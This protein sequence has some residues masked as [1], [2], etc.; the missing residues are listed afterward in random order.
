MGF[1]M[2]PQT[3]EH[4]DHMKIRGSG[5]EV[6]S[7]VACRGW[8]ADEAREHKVEREEVVQERKGERV[9]EQCGA[10]EHERCHCWKASIERTKYQSKWGRHRGKCEVG[11]K[12]ELEGYTVRG[13]VR[14]ARE[15]YYGHG[16]MCR[17]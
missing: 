11:T 6:D 12:L 2:S 1:E 9:C 3:V 10:H 5:T 14:G 7:D 15:E 13:W 4:G 17:G 16:E 8:N